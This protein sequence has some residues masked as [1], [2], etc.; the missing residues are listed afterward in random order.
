MNALQK[1]FKAKNNFSYSNSIYIYTYLCN[2][3][4]LINNGY[5][6]Y[7][8]IIK[9]FLFPL[10]KRNLGK[11]QLNEKYFYQYLKFY[12]GKKKYLNVTL[13]HTRFEETQVKMK[14]Y[15]P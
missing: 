8:T 6:K 12:L 2:S 15:L 10:S 4:Y 3:K 11:K 1:I 13:A 5:I 9:V 14:F 7:Q